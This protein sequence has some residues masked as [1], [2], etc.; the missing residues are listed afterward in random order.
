MSYND[1]EIA[2]V[3][4]SLIRTNLT[5]A[6]VKHEPQK[7]HMVWRAGLTVVFVD[8]AYIKNGVADIML[9]TSTMHTA[10]RQISRQTAR[11]FYV[12]LIKDGFVNGEQ[13]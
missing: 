7:I 13:K 8:C 3:I 10:L 4:D 9:I 5:Y 1:E 2:Q 12:N 11:I 6:D